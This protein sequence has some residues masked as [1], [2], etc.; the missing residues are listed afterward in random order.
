MQNF[1]DYYKILGINKQASADEIK[2]AYRKLARKFHPDVNPN[3]PSAE[4]KF[5]DVNEAYEVL[6]DSGKRRQ[7]DQFG[8][9]YQ[10]GGFRQPAGAGSGPF[11]P[12]GEDF[13]FGGFGNTVDFS[14][15]DDFQDFID[16]LLGRVRGGAQPGDYQ[17]ASRSSGFAADGIPSTFDAEASIQLT[18][19]EAYEGGKRKLR[20]EGG[21][22]LEISIPAGITSGKKIRLR[23]QG[24]PQPN[25][26]AGDLYL[27]VELKEHPFY[28]LEGSDLYCD[29][30]ISPSEAVLGAQVEVPT[31][32][33]SVKLRIPAGIQTGQKLRLS[34]RG[35]PKG[36][37]GR[38]DQFVVIQVNVP[39]K[40]SAEERE[41]YE[42]LQKVQS[43][44]PRSTLQV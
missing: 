41:L 16:Q 40:V 2:Q 38:G 27:K 11:S 1:K 34:N 43:Y 44:N 29:V 5:K 36:G 35:F 39:D 19:P 24:H 23:G 26:G 15:F 21:K 22:V 8:Q 10:Q 7:Y 31:L 32:D 37:G 14:Q 6:S 18:I 30:P 3:N 9:Y 20:V 33:G 17:R 42:K 12:F 28:R 25:G 13:G 4:E